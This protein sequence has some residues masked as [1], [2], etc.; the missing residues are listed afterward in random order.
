MPKPVL[1]EARFDWRGGLNTLVNPDN[2]NIDELV[3]ADN[4]RATVPHGALAK[5][6]GTRRMHAT[7]VVTGAILGVF[8]WDAPGGKEIVAVTISR[9]AHKF[10]EFGEFTEVILPTTSLGPVLFMPFRDTTANGAIVLYFVGASGVI[11][12]WDGTTVTDITGVSG[13]PQAVLLKAYHTRAFAVDERFLKQLQWSDLGTAT[14]WDGTGPTGG[15]SAIVDLLSGEGD[16]GR[17]T[18]PPEAG[19]ITERNHASFHTH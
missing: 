14:L 13:A 12:K 6:T 17:D 9:L 3:V 16:E 19:K 4:V 5:R 7:A 18:P 8:Q 11:H 1:T 15:G 2:L 10:T